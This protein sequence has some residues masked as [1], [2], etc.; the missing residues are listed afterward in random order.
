M[1]SFRHYCYLFNKT[2]VFY[3]SIHE[4]D[5][6]AMS[7]V[8]GVARHQGDEKFRAKV[9]CGSSFTFDLLLSSHSTIALLS[10]EIIYLF[11][12]S[13]RKG[14][15]LIERGHRIRFVFISIPREFEST[16]RPRE[17]LHPALFASLFDNHRRIERTHHA[18]THLEVF[19]SPFIF[20]LL[21][22]QEN[23]K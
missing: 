2:A 10:V 16:F 17:L 6:C 13:V 19:S 22:N 14:E 1:D 20:R 23:T 11:A 21:F 12:N 18:D 9:E 15:W 8:C 3:S 7:I 5:F 4:W